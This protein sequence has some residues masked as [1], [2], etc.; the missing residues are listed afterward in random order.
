[1]EG[2]YVSLS[3]KEAPILGD[4]IMRNYENVFDILVLSMS[5]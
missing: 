3:I 1:M 2:M 5:V 4:D